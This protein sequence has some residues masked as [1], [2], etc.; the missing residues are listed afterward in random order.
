MQA[1]LHQQITARGG[2]HHTGGRFWNDGDL[3]LDGRIKEFDKD[4][5]FPVHDLSISLPRSTHNALFTY[6]LEDVNHVLKTLGLPWEL[7]KDHLFAPVVL[8]TGFNWDLET[9]L[10]SLLQKKQEKYLEAVNMR[11]DTTTHT[12][13][14][15]QK[16]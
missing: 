15:T 11:F 2:R 3:L 12:L 14:D 13:D 16:L 4:M 7:T 1:A 5:Q 6:N 8:F 9:K 10:V